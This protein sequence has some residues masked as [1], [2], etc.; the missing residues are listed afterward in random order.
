MTATTAVNWINAT[1]TRTA[2]R[3]SDN[4]PSAALKLSGD[5]GPKSSTGSA[6]QR[7]TPMAVQAPRTVI[8]VTP[9]FNAMSRDVSTARVASKALR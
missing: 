4:A 3:G 9:T 2:S 7:L 6:L 5:S 1:A 8:T